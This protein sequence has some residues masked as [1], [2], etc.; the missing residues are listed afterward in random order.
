M[1]FDKRDNSV[2]YPPS[3]VVCYIFFTCSS[4]SGPTSTPALGNSARTRRSWRAGFCAR[5][6]RG[7][8]PE[9]RSPHS[10]KRR[11]VPTRLK[12]NVL[13]TC[14]TW[15]SVWPEFTNLRGCI[16]CLNSWLVSHSALNICTLHHALGHEFEPR[17]WQTLFQTQAQHL[18]ILHDSIWFIWF[19]TIFC[20]SNLSCELWN[21]N[22][23]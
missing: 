21:R 8:W 23:K 11:I 10:G 2:T 9:R 14:W 5:R 13:K 16:M 17:W 20:L 7:E 4:S 1:D 6:C 18:R 3:A 12:L 22:W 19:E 15:R